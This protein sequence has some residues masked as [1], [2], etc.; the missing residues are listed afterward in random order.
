MSGLRQR[1]A[2]LNKSL[3]N[4]FDE[5][6]QRADKSFDHALRIEFDGYRDV[7][8]GA[9]Q[10]MVNREK[11]LLCL[12]KQ[13]WEINLVLEQLVAGAAL[14]VQEEPHLYPGSRAFL[15]KCISGPL[16]R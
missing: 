16:G 12:L 3:A 15:A 6:R 8:L 14:P 10:D 1:R 13:R 4:W 9:Y 5:C 2:R 7:L 11:E